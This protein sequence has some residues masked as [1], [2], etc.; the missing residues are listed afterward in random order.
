M[1]LLTRHLGIDLGT[2]N[3]IAAEGHQILLEE[4]TI[5][6]ILIE[7]QKM[8]EWG[9][10]A[11]DMFGRVPEDSIEIV[12]PLRNGVIAE[13]E[14]TE[15]L[16]NFIV[17]K[18]CGPMML[19]RPTIM[20]TVPYGVTSVERR[21]VHEA[22]LGAGSRDV[23]LIQQPLAAAIGIDLPIATPSGN[24]I[25]S[26]GGGTSQAAVIAMNTIISAGTTR[27]AG[28]RMDESI[29]SYVRKK[30]GIIIGQPTAEQ[31]KIRIG[32]ALSMEDTLTMEVQG[33]DQVTALPRPI[34]LTTEDIV[35]S[36]QPPL[37]DIVENVKRI[38]EKTPP[39]LIS[40]IIDR[41]VAI[42]GGTSLLRNIDKYLT[43]SLGI[44]AYRVDNPYTCTAEGAA[45]AIEMRDELRRS[46]LK[47]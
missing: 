40:D 41:G 18:L 11:K 9:Q 30:Y 25:M 43:K 5:V 33:Q 14:I 28:L 37:H 19:F 16:L 12:R 46:L 8:V 3:I 22:G 21:A 4:P 31:L 6:A 44:P 2:I 32:S 24:M 13:Y 27:S 29:I 38:L 35:E 34:T 39:E 7:E 42:C 26:L 45:K 23:L 17:R 36:L 10:S 47:A 15:N 1:P 20:L